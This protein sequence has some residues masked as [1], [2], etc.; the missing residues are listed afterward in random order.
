MKVTLRSIAAFAVGAAMAATAALAT[1]AS[2]PRGGTIAVVAAEGDEA[3]SA[4]AAI[5]REAVMTALGDKGFTILDDRDHAAYIADVVAGR[6]KIGTSVARRRGAA[7]SVM[8][9]GV[10][11]PLAAN[12]TTLVAMQRVVIEIRIHK[13]GDT[14]SLWHG[15]AVTV[16][17][18]EASPAVAERLAVQ[19]SQAALGAYPVIVGSAIS[20]P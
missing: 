1:P 4:L 3:D 6:S 8:G 2:P 10:N 9:A 17:S 13:R 19:L 15:A 11:I 18:G 5:A 16:R 14:A 7:P 12:G 20:V